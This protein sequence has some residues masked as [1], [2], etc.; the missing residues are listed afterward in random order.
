MSSASQ[1]ASFGENLFAINGLN[2]TSVVRCQAYFNLVIPDR[3]NLAKRIFVQ[4]NQKHV[5]EAGSVCRGKR[6]ALLS[7]L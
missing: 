2:L 1:R 7:E 4:G 3:L 6:L 5:H